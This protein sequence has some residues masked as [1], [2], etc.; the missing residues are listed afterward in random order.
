MAELSTVRYIDYDKE[1]IDKGVHGQMRRVAISQQGEIVGIHDK[2]NTNLWE[3][4]SEVDWSKYEEDGWNCMVQIPQV[5][6]KVE[7]GTYGALEDVRRWSVSSVPSEGFKLHPAFKRSIGTYNYQYLSA[8]EGWV[9]AYQRL[10]SLPNKVVSNNLTR[11][12]FRDHARINTAEGW[13]QQDFHL[14]SLIQLLIITEFGTLD[15]QSVLGNGGSNQN[16]GRSL[17]NGNNS[18]QAGVSNYMSYRGIEN[19]YGNKY[20][21]VDGANISNR[22]WHISDN[23]KNYVDDVFTG[24]YVSY[25][26]APSTNGNIRDVH[27]LEGDKD[28]AFIP[29]E[30]AGTSNVDG[31]CDYYYQNTGNRVLVFGFYSGRA[32]AGAFFWGASYAASDRDSRIGARLQFFENI[33]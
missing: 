33:E 16:T 3:D 18:T 23:Y 7:Q 1:K 15:S 22:N 5:Y 13:A 32:D 24:D 26:V 8:F 27:M 4:G 2:D 30:I 9:D 21:W 17:T 14:T 28:F 29:S 11:A 12:E 6:Y 20:K 31:F 19:L 25:A 10:R